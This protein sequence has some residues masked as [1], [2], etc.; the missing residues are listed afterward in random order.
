MCSNTASAPLSFRFLSGTPVNM[1]DIFLP[2]LFPGI[3]SLLCQCFSFL[4]FIFRLQGW[5]DYRLWSTSVPLPAFV[6][7]VLSEHRHTFLFMYCLWQGRCDRDYMLFKPK[8]FI[9]WLFYRKKLAAP[10][11]IT[12]SP[13]HKLFLHLCSTVKMVHWVFHSDYCPFYITG[14]LIRLA[15]QFFTVSCPW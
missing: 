15:G 6:N 5:A 9:L 2:S 3:C 4:G 10:L 13:V 1:S 14:T 11:Q 7:E 8:I 12:Y